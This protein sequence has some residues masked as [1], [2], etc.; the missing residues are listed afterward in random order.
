M[1]PESRYQAHVV[2]DAAFG[3]FDKK[4]ESDD[5][6]SIRH[7]VRLSYMLPERRNGRKRSLPPLR[8]LV[9]GCVK[10]PFYTYFMFRFWTKLHIK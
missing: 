6:Y 7:G 10:K 1:A 9:P 8:N 5:P 3:G 2:Q 4:V